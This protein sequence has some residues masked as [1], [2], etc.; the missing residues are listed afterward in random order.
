[1]AVTYRPGE[2]R[3]ENLDPDTVRSTY[4]R[5]G[6]KGIERIYGWTPAVIAILRE[7]RT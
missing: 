7:N 1:M 2:S 4:Q 3:A 5:L 6:G